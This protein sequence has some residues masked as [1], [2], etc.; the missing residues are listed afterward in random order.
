MSDE[1]GLVTPVEVLRF[2]FEELAERDWFVKNPELD[3]EIERR[4]RKTHLALAGFVPDDWRASAEAYLALVIVFDQFPRNIYRGTPL[5]FATDCLALREAISA[6]DAGHDR[7]VE[8]R[9]RIFFYMPFE[10]SEMLEDQ[11]RCVEL[12]E[13]LGNERYLE[14]AHRH[15]EVIAEFNRFPHRNRILARQSTTGEVAYLAK[16]GSGF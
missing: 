14:Y 7:A 3:H 13:G 2:W 5:A 4:F 1:I 6:I 15:R 8:E 11:D 10:H 9:R 16:P 12:V